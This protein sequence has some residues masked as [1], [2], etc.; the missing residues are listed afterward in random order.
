[1]AIEEAEEALRKAMAA[2]PQ[3]TQAIL[4]GSVASGRQRY[5]SDL[6]SPSARDAG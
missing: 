2:Y 1:V 6:D 5:D 4:F 3:I